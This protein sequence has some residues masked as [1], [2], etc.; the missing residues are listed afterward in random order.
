[1]FTIFDEPD[2]ADRERAW[3]AYE[4]AS[5]KAGIS[6]TV[7]ADYAADRDATWVES[8]APEYR[9]DRLAKH[10]ARAV[11]VEARRRRYAGTDRDRPSLTEDAADARNRYLQAVAR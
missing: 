10:R 9:A 8:F 3:D 11:W 5:R 6:A 1:M 7:L 2:L 4:D